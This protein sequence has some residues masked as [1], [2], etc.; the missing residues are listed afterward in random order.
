M[1]KYKI[2]VEDGL[3]HIEDAL[4]DEGYQVV[5]PEVSGSNV[6]AYVITGM[7]EN[8][9]GMTDTMTTG[10]VI[11]ASGLDANEVLFELERRLQRQEQS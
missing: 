5:D 2:A 4:R 6:D 1:A 10:V 9:M 7:D 11:D 3:S 8:L